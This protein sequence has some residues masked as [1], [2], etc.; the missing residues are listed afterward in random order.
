MAEQRMFI[1]AVTFIIIFSAIVVSI[2]TDLLGVGESPS[3]LSA[4]DPS[5]VTDFSDSETFQKSDFV[6]NL[7]WYPDILGGY[8]FVCSFITDS[9]YIGAKSFF[10]GIW[11][12]AMSACDWTNK[13]GI[14][15]DG[16]LSFTDI[17][18]NTEDGVSKY[19]L[20]FEEGAH[21]GVFIF[22]WNT[23]AYSDSENAWD[24][25]GLYLLHGVGIESNPDVIALLISLLF[26]QLPNC[27]TLINALLA[28]PIWACVIY[29]IWFIIKES[30]PFV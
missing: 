26:L 27:P 25:D 9:F 24:N 13:D 6:A 23:T 17:D 18:S 4:I 2:P 12:G 15:N 1:F 28:T 30:L 14:K 5:F 11:L 21:A 7:Y 22:Y 20:N 8:Y 16:A 19:T 29:L 10:F 3:E